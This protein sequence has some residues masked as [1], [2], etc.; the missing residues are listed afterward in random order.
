MSTL[1]P[2]NSAGC[3][4]PYEGHQ[5]VEETA[6]KDTEVIALGGP[7]SPSCVRNIEQ[8][9]PSMYGPTHGAEFTPCR[10]VI[11][12]KLAGNFNNGQG[13]LR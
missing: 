5:V 9:L 2:Y 12:Y 10:A 7:A 11:I 1:L 3:F 8:H 13:N 4:A 6:G